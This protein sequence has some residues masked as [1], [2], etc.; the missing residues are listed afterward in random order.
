MTSMQQRAL[1]VAN[2]N[3]TH[4]RLFPPF[5]CAVLI[6]AAIGWTVL[7]AM[8]QSADQDLTGQVETL[9][10]IA[11]IGLLST[12]LIV[13]FRAGVATVSAW[14][15][16]GALNDRIALRTVAV[17][18]LTWL[19]LLEVPALVDA[20]SVVLHPGAA[21]TT[22]HIPLGLDAFMQADTPRSQILA[23]TVNLTLVAFTVALAR[24]LATRVSAGYRVA[25]PT[26]VGVAATLV[27]M[28]L[29]RA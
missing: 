16:A 26:A 15:I 18:V 1:S 5:L 9:L 27:I 25:L 19:P 6:T 10:P 17:G 4:E 20:I 28:P 12:P 23:Q 13:A 14:L 24:Y 7:Y 2:N 11:R 8:Q 29:F 22:A 21:W 3:Q